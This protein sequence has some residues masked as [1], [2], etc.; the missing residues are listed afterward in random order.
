VT[1]LLQFA[2]NAGCLVQSSEIEPT[3]KGN[4]YAQ[5]KVDRCKQRF[6]KI[7]KIEKIE[8]RRG[9]R[10]TPKPEW[11]TVPQRG[12]LLHAKAFGADVIR[13]AHTKLLAWSIRCFQL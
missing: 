12:S 7:E 13:R 8:R 2:L 6:S 3:K 5:S 1:A 4:P 9:V 10:S 11:Q